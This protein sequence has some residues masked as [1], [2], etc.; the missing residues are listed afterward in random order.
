MMVSCWNNYTG[1]RGSSVIF[2]YRGESIEGR[3]NSEIV[4]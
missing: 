2:Y 4:M 3:G 1:D